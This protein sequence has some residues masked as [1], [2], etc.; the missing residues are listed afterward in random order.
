MPSKFTCDGA[1]IS[2]QLA[3]SA[4]PAGTASFALIVADP[5]APL[6]TFVHWVIYDLPATSRALPEAMPAQ[7]QLADGSRQGRN[8]FDNLGYGGP[9]PPGHSPHHYVFT[10]YALDTKLN[11]PPGASQ[12]QVDAAMRGHVLASG[13]LIGLYNR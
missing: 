5:D 3:W 2:P 7:G 11:L 10:V 1:G 4:P 6:R 9:C 13:V 8:D 12:A